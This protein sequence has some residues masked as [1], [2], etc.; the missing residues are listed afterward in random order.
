M[1]SINDIYVNY[2]PVQA[3]KGVSLQV[4]EGEIVALIGA[5]G[6]GKTTTLAA[7][8]GMVAVQKGEIRL[9]NDPIQNLKPHLVV[10]RRVTLV[11]EGRRIFANLTVDENLRLGAYLETDR[12]VIEN[13]K[14]KV[15]NLFPRLRERI[16]QVGGTLSGGEQQML[17][18]S[19][20][21]MSDPKILLL[22]EPSLGLAPN[23]QREIFQQIRKANEA[24][25]TIVLVEQNAYQALRIADR[26]YVLE[27]GRIVLTG[28][29]RDLAD[30]PD[31]Q[32]AYL[33][34]S[35]G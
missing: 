28:L 13:R 14:E 30:N 3:L 12:S 25:V 18:I 9:N 32:A 26:A 23:L 34:G 20:A 19:R 1:I 21:L 4:K 31:V 15:F 22:D 16:N 29:G 8:M 5:N 10:K 7:I 33:G 2:G 35:R 24:G 17:A 6:A 11:P 27:N